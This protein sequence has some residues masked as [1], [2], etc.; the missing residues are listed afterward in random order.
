MYTHTLRK[1]NH[2]SLAFHH[3]FLRTGII[4]VP[5]HHVPWPFPSLWA[6][7]GTKMTRGRTNANTP[8]REGSFII[9]CLAEAF[10]DDGDDISYR[11]V[12][13]IMML[14]NPPERNLTVF[15]WVEKEYWKRKALDI[16]VV[17]INSPR[18]W[19][20]LPRNKSI[21]SILSCREDPK[22]TYLLVLQVCSLLLHPISLLWHHQ[23]YFPNVSNSSFQ[24]GEELYTLP[25]LWLDQASSANQWAV[26][27]SDVCHFWIKIFN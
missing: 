9:S 3:R 13:E 11:L 4:S 15:S 27:R 10:D 24:E 21:K 2:L 1:K 25:H 5:W 23:W 8:Y 26:S 12:M 7:P 14:Q 18:R 20:T 17:Q 16:W 19:L 22:S 6:F